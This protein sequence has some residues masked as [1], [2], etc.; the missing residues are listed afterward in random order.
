[1]S[2][3]QGLVPG[4]RPWA[5]GLFA[6][7]ARY[8]LR[9]RVSSTFRSNRQQAHLYQ[10]FL[11]GE[12]EFPAAP[13]GRSLHNFGH[14]FDLIVKDESSQRWLGEVWESWGGRWGG[15]FRD[16]IH[17]DSGATIR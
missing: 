9:P 1:M 13:P 3:F 5:S 6:V 7:A 10:K 8:G 14:A 16:P 12:S 2:G 17:F 4:L 15:R 11:R